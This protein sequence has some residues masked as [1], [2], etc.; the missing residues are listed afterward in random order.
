M[1]CEEIKDG[2]YAT[3]KQYIERGEWYEKLRRRA[4]QLWAWT[5]LALPERVEKKRREEAE[6][7]A[8]ARWRR[9]REFTRRAR[10]KKG[11]AWHKWLYPPETPPRNTS[12]HALRESAGG[13][14]YK[15][16]RDKREVHYEKTAKKREMWTKN[17]VAVGERMRQWQHSEAPAAEGPRG[18][19]P[20]GIT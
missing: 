20:E 3:S 8:R 9:L 17:R 18:A 14:R 4:R 5:Q 19:Q 16:A 15:E 11:D 10:P 12:K 1:I 6:T 7:K 13:I 2:K